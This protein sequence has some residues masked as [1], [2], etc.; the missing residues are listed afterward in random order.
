MNPTDPTAILE[1]SIA[2]LRSACAAEIK[3]GPYVSLKTRVADVEIRVHRSEFPERLE[4]VRLA[5]GPGPLSLRQPDELVLEAINNGSCVRVRRFAGGEWAKTFLDAPE[6]RA[7]N[8]RG[9]K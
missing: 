1:V 6:V 9:G 5:P 2:L 4:I 7:L 3:Q 8:V